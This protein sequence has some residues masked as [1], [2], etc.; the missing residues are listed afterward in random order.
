MDTSIT[1]ASITFFSP[2]AA[3]SMRD[4]QAVFL[5]L[6]THHLG[7]KL[8]RDALLGKDAL[9]RLGHFQI[10]AGGD[11]VEEFHHRHFAAQPLPD[12]T[13]LQPDHARAHHQQF[14]GHRFQARCAPVE[15]TICF[16]SIGAPGKRRHV[17]AGGDDDVFGGEAADGAVLAFDFDLAGSGDAAFA[18]HAFDLVLRK[19][20]STPLVS[21]PTTLSFCAIMAGR[22]RLTCALM[23]SLAKSV[24][25]SWKR[26]L[27]CSSA[28]DG[29]QPIFRQV[30]P[31]LP[32]LS[33]QAAVRP[34][35]P[36]RMA[37]L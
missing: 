13:Q 3:G 33:T 14:L 15:E 35:W 37:A 20:N 16:S 8:E 17:R 34:N 11:A 19:R 4:W 32:R 26:S 5:F 9:K 36:S 27:A 25:A 2:P 31:K 18:D 29:M 24:S 21:S 6:D 12:R 22:S 7:G 30:P 10:H 1:S 28:L 23:P